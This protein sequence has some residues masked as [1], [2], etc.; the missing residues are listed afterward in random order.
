[1]GVGGSKY[2]GHAADVRRRRTNEGSSMGQR[3]AGRVLGFLALVCA[4]VGLAVVDGIS[5]ELPGLMLCALGYYFSLTSQ[6]RAG[7]IL[8]IVA[9]GLN[10]VSIVVSGILGMPQ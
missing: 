3:V 4:V 8:V 1:V 5:I 9:A 10:V 2:D 6:D 7:Q